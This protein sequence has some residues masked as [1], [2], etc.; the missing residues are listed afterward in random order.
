M[1]I[2]KLLL[3][4]TALCSGADRNVRYVF[5]LLDSG[6]VVK[7]RLESAVPST[8]DPDTAQVLSAA[9]GASQWHSVDLDAKPVDD[10]WLGYEPPAD[11]GSIVFVSNTTPVQPL[12]TLFID[13][14]CGSC[15]GRY[16][17][18]GD[19]SVP[20]DVVT[21]GKK[22][23]VVALAN[24]FKLG[25]ALTEEEQ[26]KIAG[27]I[28]DAAFKADMD[29][30]RVNVLKMPTGFPSKD[31]IVYIAYYAIATPSS[32]IA[33]GTLR[34][35]GRETKPAVRFDALGRLPLRSVPAW[36]WRGF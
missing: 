32:G 14:M 1:R 31:G 17:F 6:F 3:L 19:K 25:K 9:N 23:K 12:L 34:P 4:A 24:G 11:P 22:L 7:A 8:G 18:S 30:L 5:S 26:T 33:P 28:G 13:A 15:F 27:K 10:V 36:G 2:W 20:A 35:T 29:S 21:T 16:S